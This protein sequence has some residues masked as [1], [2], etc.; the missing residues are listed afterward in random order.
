MRAPM[1]ASIQAATAPEQFSCMG[2]V[3][4]RAAAL[5]TVR[6]ALGAGT[7]GASAAQVAPGWRASAVSR[8]SGRVADCSL[9]RFIRALRQL[10]A[11]QSRHVPGR[12]GH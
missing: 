1:V 6:L 3:C 4:V 2:Q 5:V 8:A 9:N 7:G 11:G 10:F 12:D